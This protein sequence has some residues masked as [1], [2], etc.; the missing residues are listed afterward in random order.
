[1]KQKKKI[2]QRRV[3]NKR[4]SRKHRTKGKRYAAYLKK[5]NDAVRESIGISKPDNI[6]MQPTNTCSKVMQDP[7]LSLTETIILKS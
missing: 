2:T 7:S 6:M 5:S 3:E 4:N 1:M